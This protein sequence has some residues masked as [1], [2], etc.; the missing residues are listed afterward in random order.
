MKCPNCET[1]E[2]EFLGGDKLSVDGKYYSHRCMR[3]GSYFTRDELVEMKVD[4]QVL[5]E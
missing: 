3:C 5:M 2:V 1:N 4:K